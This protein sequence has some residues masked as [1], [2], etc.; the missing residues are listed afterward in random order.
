MPTRVVGKKHL[1]QVIETVRDKP[2]QFYFR[3][4]Q[5]ELCRNI[6]GKLKIK[7]YEF[8]GVDISKLTKIDELCEG[9]P[10]VDQRDDDQDSEKKNFTTENKA[11]GWKGNQGGGEN[12]YQK[13]ERAQE[14]MIRKWEQQRRKKNNQ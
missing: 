3:R 6:P 10:K 4:R 11:E 7:K 2:E 1:E 13:K 14:N 8:V 5:E 9:S 12:K